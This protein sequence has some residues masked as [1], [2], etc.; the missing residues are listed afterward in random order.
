E[1]ESFCIGMDIN[2]VL[3]NTLS[4]VDTE[5][6]NHFAN[7]VHDRDK[8]KKAIYKNVGKELRS[9]RIEIENCIENSNLS[10]SNKTATKATIRSITYLYNKN[11]DE[12]DKI[13]KV[14][15]KV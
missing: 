3:C 8:P 15:G 14:L 13:L 5:L 7:I 12:Y 9:C 1:I 2:S 6:H 10:T 11:N 4:R